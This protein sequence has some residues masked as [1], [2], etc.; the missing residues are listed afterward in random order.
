MT[1]V[2]VYPLGYAVYLSLFD[3]Y[4]PASRREWAGLQNY[5]RLL[6]EPRFWHS[7]A[8]TVKIVVA[9]VT[10][11]L[12]LGLLVA[13]LLFRLAPRLARIFTVLVFLPAIV[14]PVVAALFLKW[15]FV[16]QWG[17]LDGVLR[18]LGVPTPD[19]LG[20]PAWAWVTV[21]LADDWQNTPFMI[22]VLYAGLQGLDPNTLE[23][24]VIDGA[25]TWPLLRHVV[26]PAL[27]PLILFV[28]LIRAMD[29]FRIFD[30]VYVLTGGG[31]GT[32]TETITLYTYSLAFRL[33]EVGKAS[34]L[35]VLTTMVLLGLMA[36]LIAGLYRRERGAF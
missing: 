3:Y 11:Q 20:S 7:L 15:L 16:G 32:A 26:L 22:L 21:V 8:T 17:L 1:A 10:S 6:G 35:G 36:F 18:P 29:A 33:F 30:M 23:A 12:V 14:T 9:A 31:P 24:G 5:A 25:S 2:L 34:A 19:W 28:L 27:K 13:L 4:L